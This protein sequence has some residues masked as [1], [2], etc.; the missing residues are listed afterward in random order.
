VK[1]PV[2]EFVGDDFD[3]DDLVREAAKHKIEGVF[4]PKASNAHL[5]EV[6]AWISMPPQIQT[7][8]GAPGLPCGLITMIYGKRDSGKTSFATEALVSVQRENGIAIL[9]DTENKYN[10][11]RA[12]AM[13]LNPDKLI[14]IRAGSIEEAF[15]RFQA[16]VNLIKT[17]KNAKDRKV[18]CVWDSLGATPSDAEMDETVKDFSMTAAKVIKGRLRKTVRYIKDMKVAFVIINQV[19]AKMVAFGKTTQPYG[20]SGPE[21]HSALILEF[22]GMGRIRPPGA[23]AGEP[24]CGIKVKIECVKNHLA[25]PFKFGEVLID[26]KGF[27]TDRDPVYVVEMNE[28]STEVSEEKAGGDPK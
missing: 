12:K 1:Q 5:L 16:M 17:R 25:Q 10:M 18:V 24:F 28:A 2:P 7:I 23:K 11:K 21:Y 27:V 8:I 19:Y 20:G 26:G 15:D 3:A 4:V 13:G 9:I 6:T 22:V 14:L